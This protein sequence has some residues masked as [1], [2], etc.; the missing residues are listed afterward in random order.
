VVCLELEE[1]RSC[2]LGDED[3]VP[4]LSIS[5]IIGPRKKELDMAQ[6]TQVGGM[7]G[8]VAG[9]LRRPGWVTFASVI[10]FV[11]GFFY[12][13]A[14][15]SE[16]SNSYWLYSYV[17]GNVYNLAAS[18]LLWWGIFDAIIAAISI[19]AG[20]SM[21]GG[22]AFGLLTGF[23]GAGFSLL[24]WLFYIPSD[25]WLAITI[26]VLDGLVLYALASSMDFFAEAS[27][28]GPA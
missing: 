25:P 24:R 9:T 2:G 15:L 11:V 22:G 14:A 3:I 28:I 27:D 23:M 19:G 1:G 6:G 26:I 7:T 20:V 12:V 17:P 5:S 18:H 13:L 10:S 21:L 16:F 8:Y 4:D